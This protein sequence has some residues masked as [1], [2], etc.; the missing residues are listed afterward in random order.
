MKCHIVVRGSE[1]SVTLYQGGWHEVPRC[2]KACGM[3]C[4]VVQIGGHEVRR[5]TKGGA[6]K[7]HIVQRG[8]V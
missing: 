1:S 7:C 4:N 5:G 8:L 2:T 6:I 3:K